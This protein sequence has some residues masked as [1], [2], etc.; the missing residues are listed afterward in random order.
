MSHDDAYPSLRATGEATAETVRAMR[1]LIM[2]EDR[3]V[4][5]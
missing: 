2:M 3:I 4:L 1:V 5:I